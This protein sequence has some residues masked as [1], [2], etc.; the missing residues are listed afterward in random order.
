MLCPRGAVSPE[1]PQDRAVG[2]VESNPRCLSRPLFWR[3]SAEARFLVPFLI[4]NSAGSDLH[5]QHGGVTRLRQ[6]SS[7]FV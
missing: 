2:K 6:D 1:G 4:V 3:W 7:A 5:V